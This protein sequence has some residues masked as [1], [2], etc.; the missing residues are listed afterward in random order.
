[1]K[2][3]ADGT[4]GGAS[5]KHGE[6]ENPEFIESDEAVK[7]SKPENRIYIQDKSSNRTLRSLL[8]K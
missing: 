7:S 1:L 4:Q 2:F 3:V 6:I 5:R 8:L